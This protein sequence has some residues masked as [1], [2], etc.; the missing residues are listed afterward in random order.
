MVLVTLTSTPACGDTV[1]YCY[2][3]G[4]NS[5]FS[6]TVDNVG[7]YI[8]VSIIE[9]DVEQGY[10]DLIIYDSSDDSEIYHTGS[11]DLTGVS[12]TSTTG[13][14]SVWVDADSSVSC[15]NPSTWSGLPSTSLVMDITCT[16]PPSCEDPTDLT[17]SDITTTTASVSWTANNAETAWEYQV[18]ESGVSPA[19]TGLAT[20]DNPL[21]LSGLVDNTAYDLY[22]RANCGTDGI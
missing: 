6:A 17:V 21:L 20:S 11:G 1:T 22:L 15:L 18:V 8:T 4:L 2:D 13:I 19:E 5:V 16:P 7:D 10:D 14:I 3:N 9:G 12:I